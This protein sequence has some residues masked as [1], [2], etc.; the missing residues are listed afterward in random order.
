MR[1]ESVKWLLTTIYFWGRLNN[2][3][4]DNTKIE[5]AIYIKGDS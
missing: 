2:M 4:V 3:K 1:E 5:T